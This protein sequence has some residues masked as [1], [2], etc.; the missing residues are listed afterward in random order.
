VLFSLSLFVKHVS[1]LKV[2][3]SAPEGLKAF[4]TRYPS[5]KVVSHPFFLLLASLMGPLQVTGWIDEGLNERAYIVPGLGDFGE[6][7]CVKARYE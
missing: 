4:T 1:C 7:R 5:L 3:V 6:R 2:Q